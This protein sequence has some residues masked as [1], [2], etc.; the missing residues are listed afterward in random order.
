MKTSV[1]INI[2]LGGGWEEKYHGFDKSANDC[3][4][5]IIVLR[6]LSGIIGLSFAVLKLQTM[7]CL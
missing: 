2:A 5:Y 7:K 4:L 1:E 6:V 3:E